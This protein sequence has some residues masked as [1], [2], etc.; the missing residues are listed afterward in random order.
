M[1][2]RRLESS[3][4]GFDAELARLTRYEAAQDEAVEATVR[5]IIAEVRARGDA[6]LIEYTR[7]LDRVEARSIAELE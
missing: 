2:L 6:A 4:E 3:A 7:K 1:K 5:A